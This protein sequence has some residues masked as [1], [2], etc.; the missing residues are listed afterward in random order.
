MPDLWFVAQVPTPAL[1]TFRWVCAHHGV[2]PYSPRTRIPV[3]PRHLRRPVLVVRPAYPGYQFIAEGRLAALLNRV[4]RTLYSLLMVGGQPATVS[5]QEIARLRDREA[6]ALRDF[7]DKAA[8]PVFAQ[9]ATVRVL[10]GL[11]E[12]QE[13]V[14]VSSRNTR[15]YAEVQFP[16]ASHPV[17]IPACLL[18]TSSV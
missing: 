16:G 15:G 8:Q 10:A 5:T 2:E 12:G 7:D 4:P 13:G 1:L 17:K 6:A 18:D 14:V 3:R 9:G 11:M